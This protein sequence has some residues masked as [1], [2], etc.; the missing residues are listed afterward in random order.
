MERP[1]FGLDYRSILDGMSSIVNDTDF[2]IGNFSRFNDRMYFVMSSLMQINRLEKDAT[3]DMI[4]GS[5]SQASPNSKHITNEA[6]RP[7]YVFD[8]NYVDAVNSLYYMSDYAGS[9]T[10][11]RRAS[12]SLMD[13]GGD[14]LYPNQLDSSDDY[15]AG[16]S[17]NVYTE[18][19]WADKN[20]ILYKTKR[21]FQDRKI[22]SLIEQFGT[23]TDGGGSEYMQAGDVGSDEYG[24]SKGRN[25][26]IKAAET[27]GGKY[28]ERGYN[29]PYCRVWTYFHKYN[30]AKDLMR[31][32]RKEGN[33]EVQS[34]ETVHS[35]N[36]EG[37][38]KW[39]QSENSKP[40][41]KTDGENTGEYMWKDGHSARWGLSVLNNHSDGLVNITP[42]YNSGSSIHTKDCM[43]SIENLAWKDYDPYKFDKN[44]SW[45]QRGPHG[46]RIM[47]FPPYGLE[48]TET[49][50]A[51]WAEN[52]FIG[53]G[54]HV[55]TY[56]NTKRS[57]N[58]SFLLLVDHP[59]V[60]DYATWYNG[61]KGFNMGA[62]VLNDSDLL[63]YFAGCDPADAS[64][65]DKQN[66]SN[67]NSFTRPTPRA[68]EEEC[69]APSG[70]EEEKEAKPDEPENKT[71]TKEET[72]EFCVYYPNNYSGNFDC[73]D[74][75]VGGVEFVINYLLAGRNAQQG[76]VLE[77]PS[78]TPVRR[79]IPID[80]DNAV[81]YEIGSSNGIT[82]E[83]PQS[84]IDSQTIIGNQKPWLQTGS[85][86]MPDRTKMWYYRIDGKYE[87]TQSTSM[88]GNNIYSN[89]YDQVLKVKT[90]YK[91]SASFRLN[92][93]LDNQAN[94]YGGQIPDDA[95]TFS[96]VAEA[97][98]PWWSS[99]FEKTISFFKN[100]PSINNNSGRVGYLDSLF[101]EGK[102]TK[103]QCIGYSNS[104]GQNPNDTTNKNRNEILATKRAETIK[105]WLK[106]NSDWAN[107]DT[108][109]SHES[110][111]F[112]KNETKNNP[113]A[114]SLEA[115]IYRMAKC[116]LTFQ[117]DET[118]T[119]EESSEEMN[120]NTEVKDELKKNNSEEAANGAETNGDLVSEVS[121]T[122]SEY[123][124]K[125]WNKIRYDQEF[126]FF[127]K[128]KD[129]HPI[130][131]QKLMDKLQYFNP[132]FH[133]MTPEGFNS[134]L[135]FLNQCTRAGETISASD[136]HRQSASNMAFGRPPFCVLRV[137]DFYNQ[138]IVINQIHIDYNVSDGLMWDLNDEGAGVQPM[139]AK[140]TIDFNFIGG[141]S[142]GG[143]IRRL[144]NAMTFN[145]YANAELYDN[146]ADH[147]S[148]NI[149]PDVAVGGGEGYGVIDPEQS[150]FRNVMLRNE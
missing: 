132:A 14:N 130:A 108:E 110:A 105:R 97:F 80:Y 38:K 79:I 122:D 12:Q 52:Q 42:K 76:F 54:E 93:S 127:K 139:L 39:W 118:E 44:L 111:Q 100:S 71:H 33:G 78:N 24:M 58:L 40:E 59:S 81:G 7:G 149:D 51:Q 136:K 5:Q 26:L 46:G 134:R 41:T 60:T 124:D 43:F 61:E 19:E 150:K 9:H 129:E 145:Y 74:D 90:N 47:W 123:A 84:E 35:W 56:V 66:V 68:H 103:I 114:N 27:R 94:V 70:K 1:V 112:V 89:T 128:F 31:P 53:R 50:S 6:Q 91:D 115:K 17:W 102:L 87:V 113:N 15:I 37:D 109:I 18:D 34:L 16:R 107:V 133:S 83:L 73:D 22:G 20:S 86:Y 55:Y 135:T 101:R 144:Q 48:F 121:V 64:N 3:L 146:R 57:G 28:P 23:N 120:T 137:G 141:G 95:Y 13:E 72:V 147:V 104:H 92:T 117:V 88:V 2:T 10:T 32:F 30:T 119:L 8:N 96:E 85:K 140:V 143:A 63:R 36:A 45:E 49:T 116:I 142:L 21:L 131:Y 4:S 65:G 99:D 25:L 82:T 75:E 125:K 29:N 62:G 77:Q 106:M 11:R 67:L 126:F 98:I 69:E 138:M 148:Y